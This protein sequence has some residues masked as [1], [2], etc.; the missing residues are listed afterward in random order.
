MGAIMNF[1]VRAM[2]WAGLGSIVAGVYDYTKVSKAAGQPLDVRGV[3]MAAKQTAQGF[4]TAQNLVR[5]AIVC[6]VL[7]LMAV[8]LLPKLL[9]KFFKK[10]KK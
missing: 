9:P 6:V 5:V 8:F 7:A 10:P 3:G 1:V 4:F 2:I